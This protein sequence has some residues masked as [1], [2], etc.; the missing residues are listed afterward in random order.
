[1]FGVLKLL[2][3]NLHR[4]SVGRVIREHDDGRREE[5]VALSGAAHS[6]WKA[7]AALSG[8]SVTQNSQ[9]EELLAA[10]RSSRYLRHAL[11]LWATDNLTWARLYT[12]LETL[13]QHLGVQAD[14]AQLCSKAERGRFTRTANTAEVSGRESRHAP[15]LFEAPA[16]PMSLKEATAFI[17]R[18]LT[19][20]LRMSGA[21]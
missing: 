13:E 14:A 20:A 2:V 21:V 17:E 12:I 19:K 18:L 9:A 5:F 10:A 15:G 6:R 1:M 11:D 16:K 3:G 4:P 7:V 8:G